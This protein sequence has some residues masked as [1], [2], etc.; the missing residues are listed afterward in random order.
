MSKELKKEELDVELVEDTCTCDWEARYNKQ[1]EYTQELE[2]KLLNSNKAFDTIY[3]LLVEVLN[4]L[5]SQLKANSLVSIDT[6][7][8]L[9]NLIQ[10]LQIK[11]KN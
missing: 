8:R 4:H 11:N 1:V 9:D 7:R 5:D 10:D 2:K 3:N 6:W